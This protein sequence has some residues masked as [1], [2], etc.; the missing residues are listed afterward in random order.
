MKYVR[1]INALGTDMWVTE[2][3]VDEYIAAGHTLAAEPASDAKPTKAGKRR[4]RKDD[5]DICDGNG[6]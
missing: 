3:R 2:D 6:C 5:S 1:M 4:R